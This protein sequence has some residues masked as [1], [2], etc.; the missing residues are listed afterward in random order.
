MD[1]EHSDAFTASERRLDARALP[2]CPRKTQD[3]GVPVQAF[4]CGRRG[5]HDPVCSLSPTALDRRRGR[6]VERAAE[7]R[8]TIAPPARACSPRKDDRRRILARG[9]GKDFG[10]LRALD[11][12]DSRSATESSSACWGRTAREDTTVHC[13][14]RCSR[15]RAVRR[16]SRTRCRAR[17][18]AVR[19]SI[20]L[21][22]QDT[23]SI[24]T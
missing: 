9:L 22:F 2:S 3:F 18:L 24:A 6:A 4:W 7:A 13:W 21:V 19:R 8:R 17:G 12:L 5:L 11:R 14:R 16:A 15:L 23:R 10:A 20:G 1:L